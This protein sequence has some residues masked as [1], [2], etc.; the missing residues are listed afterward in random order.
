[1]AW[2]S[3]LL[4][5]RIGELNVLLPVAYASRT[6]IDAERRYSATEREGLAVVWAVHQF[7]SYVMGM[8]FVVVTDHSALKALR[9]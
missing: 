7:K 2:V 5:P 8:P 3:V 4:L 9:T 6:L 1:M